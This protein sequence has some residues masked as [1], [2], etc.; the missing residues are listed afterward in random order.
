MMYDDDMHLAGA[1]RRHK[2]R[3]VA[4]SSPS[5][6]P[7]VARRHVRHAHK[8]RSGSSALARPRPAGIVFT[9]SSY[10]TGPLL[11]SLIRPRRPVAMVRPGGAAVDVDALFA[12][13]FNSCGGGGGKGAPR[14]KSHLAGSFAHRRHRH[15]SRALA[16]MSPIASGHRRRVIRR[17]RP[18]SSS[19]VVMGG[20]VRKRRLVRRR[21]HTTRAATI[22]HKRRVTRHAHR[23]PSATR[24]VIGARRHHRRR[25]ASHHSRPRVVRRVRR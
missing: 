18:A 24:S 12:R 22:A 23:R 11:P 9:S 4:H 8:R 21:V 13:H 20:P 19:S 7:L 6:R 25:V 3:R 1:A 15:V 16:T 14:L 2:R 17:R 5:S 10:T